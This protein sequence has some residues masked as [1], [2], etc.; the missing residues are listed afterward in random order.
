MKR[1]NLASEQDFSENRWRKKLCS[2]WAKGVWGLPQR[3]ARSNIFGLKLFFAP[4]KAFGFRKTVLKKS[5]TNKQT[6][7]ITSIHRTKCCR[8]NY[9]CFL[10]AAASSRPVSSNCVTSKSRVKH[11]RVRFHCEGK[12]FS[13]FHEISFEGKT[14]GVKTDLRSVW[15]ARPF[16]HQRWKVT[17]GPSSL[18]TA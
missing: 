3:A 17:L 1:L 14:V 2:F 6:W 16:F 9:I 4:L 8:V 13:F 5:Q 10:A 12:S 7:D 11:S 18:W 15:P